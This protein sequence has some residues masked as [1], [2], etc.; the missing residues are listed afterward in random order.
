MIEFTSD[1]VDRVREFLRRRYAPAAEDAWGFE[2]IH[3]TRG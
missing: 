2:S 3:R 1:R